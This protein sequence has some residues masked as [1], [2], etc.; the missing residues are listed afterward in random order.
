MSRMSFIAPSPCDGLN[1]CAADCCRLLRVEC[2][3]ARRRTSAIAVAFRSDEDWNLFADS[4]GMPDEVTVPTG[5]SET[6]R[7]RGDYPGKTAK[8]IEWTGR[9]RPD[10]GPARPITRVSANRVDQK[11]SS[12]R[13]GRTSKDAKHQMRA[14]VAT[15]LKR[16]SIR[17]QSRS[18]RAH[19]VPLPVDIRIQRA[20]PVRLI[21]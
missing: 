13:V 11:K 3:P 9:Q 8:N 21:L 20:K 15:A 7:C 18:Q 1:R 6:E 14:A 4:L 19:T 10:T 2:R 17:E 16:T 12:G 5:S